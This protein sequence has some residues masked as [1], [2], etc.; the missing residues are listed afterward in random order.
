LPGEKEERAKGAEMQ[1]DHDRGHAPVD[2]LM[3]GTV[4]FDKSA[5]AHVQTQL[6]H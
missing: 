4:V 5:E 3:K 6:Y 1:P 2:G